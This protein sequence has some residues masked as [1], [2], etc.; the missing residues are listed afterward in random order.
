MSK[1]FR[2][3]L[4]LLLFVVLLSPEAAAAEESSAARPDPAA[5]RDAALEERIRALED[6]A[7]AGDAQAGAAAETAFNALP[8]H[9]R[10]MRFNELYL[11]AK[12]IYAVTGSRSFTEDWRLCVGEVIINRVYSP[13][14]PDTY[15][16][17]LGQDPLYSGRIP[18][19]FPSLRPDRTCVRIAF[20]LLQGERLMDDERVVYQDSHYYDG[21]VCKS[22]YDYRVGGV[23]FC[24]STHP[25]LYP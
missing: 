3:V 4:L 25:E 15:E 5:E 13:E 10:D 6:A 9:G 11:L 16:E 12:G 20:R 19:Y 1:R 14:F 22:L 18:A 2:S 7:I 21:G 8:E 24:Y 17:V 23:Y